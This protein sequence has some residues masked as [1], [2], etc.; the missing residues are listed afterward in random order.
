MVPLQVFYKDGFDIKQPTVFEMTLTKKSKETNK[1]EGFLMYRLSSQ[2]IDTTT[3]I[4]ILNKTV[5]I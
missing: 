3:H 2:E 1:L 4:Q 5:L